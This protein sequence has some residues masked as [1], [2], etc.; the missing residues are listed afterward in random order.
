M[1]DPFENDNAEYLVLVNHENQ[2]SLWPAFKEIPAGWTATGPKGSRKLCLDWV[3][4]NWTDMRPRSLA[5][6]M[7]RAAG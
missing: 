7:D 3:D 6:K 5:E 1:T 4:A 2:Y